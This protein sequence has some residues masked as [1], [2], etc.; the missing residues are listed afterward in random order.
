MYK[1]VE[2]VVTTRGGCVGKQIVI[3][4]P[5]QNHI[6]VISSCMQR[7]SC[8][9]TRSELRLECGQTTGNKG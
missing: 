9:V 6:Q 4:I 3:V 5:H 7:V 1:S 8:N 2:Q